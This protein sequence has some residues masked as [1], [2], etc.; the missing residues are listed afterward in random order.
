MSPLRP[1]L[2]FAFAMALLLAAVFALRVGLHIVY[3]A[4]PAHQRQQIAPWMTP[5]YV[6]HSWDVPRADVAR[7][8][9][10]TRDRARSGRTLQDIAEARGEDPWMLARRLQDALTSEGSARD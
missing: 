7:A 3:W 2:R 10:L 5:G 9:D 4:D 1:T 6:A 8:L